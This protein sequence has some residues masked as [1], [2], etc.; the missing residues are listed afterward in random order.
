MPLIVMLKV[1]YP[2]NM[3]SSDFPLLLSAFVD[4]W[5]DQVLIFMQEFTAT[6]ITL[7]AHTTSIKANFIRFD[8]VVIPGSS[9]QKQE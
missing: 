9:C 5:L 6:L 4:Y 1:C 8:L 7:L 3:T 2:L